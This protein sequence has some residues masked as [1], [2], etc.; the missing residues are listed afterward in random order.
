[1]KRSSTLL[2]FGCVLVVV[3]SVASLSLQEGLSG[4]EPQVSADVKARLSELQMSEDDTVVERMHDRVTGEQIDDSLLLVR[5]PDASDAWEID[6][7]VYT[8]ELAAAKAH[9]VHVCGFSAPQE[10]LAEEAYPGQQDNEDLPCGL[11]DARDRPNDTGYFCEF[12]DLRTIEEGDDGFLMWGKKK[13]RALEERAAAIAAEE[14]AKHPALIHVEIMEVTEEHAA[15]EDPWA[16]E[17]ETMFDEEEEEPLV[18]GMAPSPA[19]STVPPSA[20]P[21]PGD[22]RRRLLRHGGHAGSG[23]RHTLRSGPGA[24]SFVTM[25]SAFG[26]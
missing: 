3:E 15:E 9:S 6:F 2:W 1:M 13:L 14:I 20:A 25:P 19:P 7:I 8:T 12:M 18:P 5:Y 16:K 11:S 26:R 22:T 4:L 24:R 21:S 10:C 23:V 17:Q